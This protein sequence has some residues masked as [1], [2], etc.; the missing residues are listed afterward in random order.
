MSSKE[1]NE[2]E[3][4]YSFE[5]E[6]DNKIAQF[7]IFQLPLR[8]VLTHLFE[9]IDN[10]I[11]GDRFG[12]SLSKMQLEGEALG[13][14]LS[15]LTHFLKKCTLEIENSTIN[16]SLTKYVEELQQ[17]VA[18]AHFCE[19]MPEV[20]RG[21]YEVRKIEEGFELTHPSQKFS[22]AE[23]LDILLTEI[24]LGFSVGEAPNLSQEFITLAGQLPRINMVLMCKVLKQLFQYHLNSIRETPI[25]EPDSFQ[26]SIGVTWEEFCKVRSAL[27]A[28]SDFSI[29]LANYLEILWLRENNK[30]REEEIFHEFYEWVAVFNNKN[31]FIGLLIAFTGVKDSVIESILSFFSIHVKNQDFENSGEGFFPPLVDYSNSYLFSPHILR[32]M[33][34]TRNIFYV[35]NKRDPDKFSNIISKYLE[36]TLLNQASEILKSLPD[37]R[38]ISNKNWSK[39]E[40]DLLIYQS[41]SNTVVQIQAKAP[42]PPQGARMTKAVEGRSKEGIDQLNRFQNLPQAERDSVISEIFKMPVKQVQCVSVLLCRAGLGTH[43]VWELK[44]D[45]T[46]LNLQLLNGVAQ[47]LSSEGLPLSELKEVTDRLLTDIHNKSVLGWEQGSISLNGISISM[48]LLRLN[49]DEIHKIRKQL[50]LV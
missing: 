22:R 43:S 7:N 34:A 24:S 38:I 37:L 9:A 1:M 36:P 33:L 10:L 28:Y 32:L 20:R 42:I 11:K 49:S 29:G 41:S 39:G 27:L 45:I 21:Y 6:V 44:K 2:K 14:R 48:P 47:I 19:I 40:F 16:Y 5:K 3:K 17:V 30:K 15:Y 12:P 8:I 50:S 46:I 26:I 31:Y 13:S 18:Y 4:L 23:E 25:L 35:L